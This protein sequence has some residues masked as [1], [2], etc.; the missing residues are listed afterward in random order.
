MLSIVNDKNLKE[1]WSILP[2]ARLVGG[3]VRDTLLG[4]TPKDID[5]ATPTYPEEVIELFKNKGFN[6]IETGISH[7]TVTV[8]VNGTGYEIT[9]LRSDVET[10]GRH[11]TVQWVA[12]WKQDAMRRDFTFNA[13]YIDRN[14]FL[15]DYFNGQ[16]DIENKTVRF[17]GNADE[18]VKEDALRILR[19]FRFAVRFNAQNI[20]EDAKNA[21]VN[22][23]DMLKNL[24]V[25]RVHSEFT[26]IFNTTNNLWVYN[27]MKEL[28]VFDQFFSNVKDYNKDFKNYL[29][30]YS[31]M[32]NGEYDFMRKFKAS[33]DEVKFVNDVNKVNV[34]SNFD[35]NEL[36]YLSAYEGFSINVIKTKLD[37]ENISYDKTIFDDFVVPIFPVTGKDLIN[38]GVK[39]G[40]E[41]GKLLKN[42][43]K[44]WMMNNF[45]FDKE[46]LLERM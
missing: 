41:M 3:C 33:I 30:F 36:K 22:N 35:E 19:Y 1:I 2:N 21:I 6:V 23:I 37:I 5:L 39:P 17:V 42:L 28:K 11:A 32:S 8:M 14:G 10:D 34:T 12:D 45:I 46:E 44:I 16:K 20:D 13:M 24:S 38:V 31:F 40:V 43:K 4:I 9:T 26:K 25:E 7:G 18:R 29:E 15:Y 27:L